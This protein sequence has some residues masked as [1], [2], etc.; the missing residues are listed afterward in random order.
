MTDNHPKERD[1]VPTR[2]VASLASAVL[3]VL[4]IAAC[5]PQ[6]R[7]PELSGT[8]EFPRI[9][10]ANRWVD[11]RVTGVAD[12]DWVVSEATLVSPL[13]TRMDSQAMTVRL[14]ADDPAHVKVP[15]GE[16]VCDADSGPTVATITMS[17]YGIGAAVGD[18]AAVAVEVPLDAQVLTEIHA[19]ECAVRAVTDLAP[20]SIGPGFE[21]DGT[22]VHTTLTM[23]RA[24]DAPG[25]VTVTL[26]QLRGSVIFDLEPAAALPASLEAG[27]DSVSVP[28][29]F[30]ASR[31]D[32]HAFAE[33]KKTFV[34]GMWLEAGGA[35]V[36]S[37]LRPDLDMKEALQAAFN[38][39][40][41]A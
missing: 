26:T 15:L 7:A 5:D 12:S 33:S 32:P 19:D 13:F 36:F 17:H 3:L 31:C 40:G 16:A 34:F 38:A 6:S 30:T 21:L 14:F 8:V 41:A 22:S 9:L 10:Q 1:L 35:E 20:A 25:E 23:T 28:V 4:V 27:A 18:A 24:A 37:E 39:C 29:T 11:L 2:R